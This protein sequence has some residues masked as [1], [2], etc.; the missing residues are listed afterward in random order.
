MLQLIFG[1]H[2][3]QQLRNAVSSRHLRPTLLQHVVHCCLWSCCVFP[4][5]L[6]NTPWY[7]PCFKIGQVRKAPHVCA[8]K[9]CMIMMRSSANMAS[10]LNFSRS[11]HHPSKKK[12]KLLWF[13]TLLSHHLLQLFPQHLYGLDPAFVPCPCHNGCHMSTSLATTK[14]HP[15]RHTGSMTGKAICHSYLDDGI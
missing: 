8:Q 11:C 13:S 15:L 12:R 4:T 6:H 9:M 14:S 1:V 2:V 5:T 10:S 7:E 3:R